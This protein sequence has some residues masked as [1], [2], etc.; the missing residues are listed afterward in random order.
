MSLTPTPPNT[1]KTRLYAVGDIHGCLDKLLILQQKIQADTADFAG[2]THLVY[3][4]DYIDR[5][6]YSKEVIETLCTPLAGL[7]TVDYILGNHDKN[8]LNL[9][10]GNFVRPKKAYQNWLFQHGGDATLA[11]YGFL[12]KQTA[13]IAEISRQVQKLVPDS[14]IQFLKRLKPYVEVGKFLC[15]HGGVNP[16]IPLEKQDIDVLTHARPASFQ[17]HGWEKVIIFGHT[18]SATPLVEHDRI[19]I[20]TGAYTGGALTCAVVDVED[21]M[22]SLR[23]ITA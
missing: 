18:I 23:F 16:S 14:H 9:I 13:D 3:V 20:D 1:M 22:E 21:G 2:K 5:G 19:G 10:E 15:V 6:L 12:P 8:F 4:G 17:N 11:S 7:D